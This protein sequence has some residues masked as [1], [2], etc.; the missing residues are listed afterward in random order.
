[1]Q[2]AWD[3]LEKKGALIKYY[4]ETLSLHLSVSPRKDSEDRQ[5]QL[6]LCKALLLF[7]YCLCWV[8]GGW[9]KS[10]IARA[11]AGLL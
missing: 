2:N 10:L 9:G 3:A 11:L 4:F 5:L 7:S 1:M 6:L 8:R